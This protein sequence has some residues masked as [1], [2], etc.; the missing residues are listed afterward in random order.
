MN[1]FIRGFMSRCADNPV[2]F[3]CLPRSKAKPQ[4]NAKC[5]RARRRVRR[6]RSD[7]AAG[8]SHLPGGKIASLQ[9]FRPEAAGFKENLRGKPGG[10]KVPPPECA[11]QALNP[12]SMRTAYSG[13]SSFTPKPSI[14]QPMELT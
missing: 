1:Q 8:K 9:V 3:P 2:S 5:N 13:C 10:G 7:F 12:H 11:Y 6:A 14:F 4:Q